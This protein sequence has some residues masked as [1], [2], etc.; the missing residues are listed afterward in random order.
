MKTRDLFKLK[1]DDIYWNL[2][3]GRSIRKSNFQ[4]IRLRGLDV[5]P[6]VFFLSTG[7]CGTNWFY[8]FLSN[9]K[10][11]KTFHEPIPNLGA[12]GRLVYN[13]YQKSGFAPDENEKQLMKEIFL[14]GREQ[15]LRYS[16]KTNKAFIE[17]NNHVTF[18]APLLIELFPKAK[19]IH[20][21][22]HPGEFARSAMRRNF[23]AG[24]SDDIKRIKP[25]SGPYKEKWETT[26][27][28]EKCAW[29]WKETNAY[30]ERIRKF[31]PEEQFF[32]FNLQ[33]AWK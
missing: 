24:T 32:F 23:Y 21:V 10:A 26:S 33:P 4:D 25:L 11:Y 31:I 6:P 18:F 14:A 16:Y 2:K 17:T 1:L 27:Q 13:N 8:Y 7:R 28:A 5:P 20:L 22:R 15:F 3:F 30:I 19:F 9:F 12:Q 29:L